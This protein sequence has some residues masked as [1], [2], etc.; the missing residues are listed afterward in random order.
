MRHFAALLFLLPLLSCSRAAPVVNSF[1]ELGSETVLDERGLARPPRQASGDRH[2][3]LNG[4]EDAGAGQGRGAGDSHPRVE[5]ALS[6][7]DSLGAFGWLPCPPSKRSAHCPDCDRINS[8][9]CDLQALWRVLT[10]Y[11]D[12]PT[13]VGYSAVLPSSWSEAYG[14]QPFGRMAVLVN[15]W[16]DVANRQVGCVNPVTC[17]N[18]GQFF[19]CDIFVDGNGTKSALPIRPNGGYPEPGKPS[20][21][22]VPFRSLAHTITA[23]ALNGS[24][25][26]LAWTVN[27]LSPDIP[28]ELKI[29]ITIVNSWLVSQAAILNWAINLLP[30]DILAALQLGDEWNVGLEYTRGPSI[31]EV[32]TKIYAAKTMEFINATSKSWP[33]TPPPPPPPPTPPPCPGGSLKAC[34]GLCPNT[35]MDAQKACIQECM[36]VCNHA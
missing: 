17:F 16:S 32:F 1:H 21:F 7:F 3:G 22:D 19:G 9:M 27:T 13:P 8:E 24:D 26:N 4:P 30:A 14:P 33:W 23:Y 34:I 10:A 6:G 5:I 25:M 20:C 12:F 36:D 35:P 28:S 18:L 11:G 29:N 15:L 2:G 31:R